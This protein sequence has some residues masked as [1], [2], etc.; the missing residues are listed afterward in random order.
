M[1]YPIKK[2]SNMK[3]PIDIE[4]YILTARREYGVDK[5]LE[6]KM[7][8]LMSLG[9]ESYEDGLAGAAGYPMDLD[10]LVKEFQKETGE[11]V[12]V[13]SVLRR[14]VDIMNEAYA[15]GQRDAKEATV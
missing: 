13:S 3:Y 7:R 8:L 2:L 14:I 9:N 4:A 6:E 10:K 15:Q 11:V 5:D 1:K 12:P